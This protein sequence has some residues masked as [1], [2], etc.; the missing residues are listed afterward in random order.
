MHPVG[1][2]CKTSSTSRHIHFLPHLLVTF[3]TTI[4]LFGRLRKAVE[5]YDYSPRNVRLSVR[6]E[7][8][9]FF[10]FSVWDFHHSVSTNS[11]FCY[12]RIKSKEYFTWKP[13]DIYICS[14]WRNSWDR[15]ACKSC[16]LRGIYYQLLN[17][18]RIC[19]V[20]N[21]SSGDYNRAI[22]PHTCCINLY[23][24]LTVSLSIPPYQPNCQDWTNCAGPNQHAYHLLHEGCR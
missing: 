16:S 2:I 10:R 23:P 5:K 24:L 15:K 3:F 18:E 20:L 19:H 7:Q 14:L 9:I 21:L 17:T 8:W 13:T 22:V 1:F 11:H 12:H 6:M 4:T